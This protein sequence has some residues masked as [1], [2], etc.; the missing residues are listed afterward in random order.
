MKLHWFQATALMAV[1]V[2]MDHRVAIMVVMDRQEMVAMDH[3]AMVEI[4]DKAPA[5]FHLVLQ[6][7]VDQMVDQA[8]EAHQVG[9]VAHQVAQDLEVQM[10]S[11]QEGQDLE[12]LQVDL[13]SEVH[14][15]AQDSEARQEAQDSEV[16]QV[17]QDSEARQEVQDSEAHLVQVE[18]LHK[19]TL[20]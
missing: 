19:A 7:L 12:D 1:V 20:K 15:V 13:D 2:V 3:Q 11:V 8:L 10:D 9:S 14:L 18:M 16:R 5:D 6:D 4:T 17:V